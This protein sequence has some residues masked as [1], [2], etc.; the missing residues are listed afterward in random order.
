PM[1]VLWSKYIDSSDIVLVLVS[2]VGVIVC[3]LPGLAVYYG[4]RGGTRSQA[5]L[6]Q[7]WVEV[8]IVLSLAWGLWIYSL[9]FAP[10]WG[11]LPEMTETAP[12]FENLN[13][14]AAAAHS[15][16]AT[17]ALVPFSKVGTGGVIGGTEFVGLNALLPLGDDREPN[18]PIHRPAYEIP[19]AVLMVFQMSLFLAAAV[20]L[21]LALGRRMPWGMVLLTAV[22][23]GT[24]VYA[25]LVH[26]I[27]GSGWLQVLGAIDSAGGMLQ[28]AVGCSGLACACSALPIRN[29]DED[30]EAG[31]T[32]S[33]LASSLGLP[34]LWGGML[35]AQLGCAYTA[36]PLVT[37]YLL[38]G[39]M[40]AS[41]GGVS[42]M[43]MSYVL[44][45][46]ALKEHPGAGVIAGLASIAGGCG[47]V[48]VTSALIIGMTGGVVT[49][50]VF[51]LVNQRSSSDN[52]RHI[53]LLHGLPG[54]L[55][56]LLTGVFLKSMTLGAG[57]SARVVHGLIAGDSRQLGWQA[58]ALAFGVV[59]SFAATWTLLHVVKLGLRVAGREARNTAVVVA[60]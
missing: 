23:W 58:L 26:A 10:S 57:A 56:M 46:P 31:S 25:P 22:L 15:P 12:V 49:A 60:D 47:Y 50:T 48:A 14:M 18:F 30:I 19:H 33:A 1:T 4:A 53:F 28:I 24:F 9:A 37:T 54:A 27:W 38:N 6:L 44:K 3:L 8:P 52:A 11:T 34:L 13:E 32:M 36:G 5:S 29:H 55:G 43:I 45:S 17:E 21:A 39:C 40:A 7:R 2:A 20:P 41:A 42:W 35:L 16:E 59:W 51:A